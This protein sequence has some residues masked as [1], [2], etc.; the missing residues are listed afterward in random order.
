MRSYRLGVADKDAYKQ[1]ADFTSIS[2]W[3][4]D[5]VSACINAKVFEGLYDGQN[6]KPDGLVT[7]AEVCKL[8]YNISSPAHTVTI[9]VLTGGTITA[10]PAAAHAGTVIALTVTPDAGK[11]LKAGTLKY[12][13]TVIS[14]TT[15]T[16]PEKDVTI[17]AEFE[18]IPVTLD[19]I[20]ITS[21]PTKK[22]YTVGETLDL[23]GLVITANYSNNTHTAITG[24]T[25]TPADSST[26]STAGA[27]AVTASYTEGAVTKTATF[28]IQVNA[29]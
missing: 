24:Y 26:L 1:Y 28:T 6:F 9:G 23:S 25:T 18:D 4:Q 22:T 8:I 2:G 12:D 27:I 13:E 14:G 19:S 15:F 7:R 3:A 11:Q 16:M 21:E 5:S 20:T 29:A 17:T 10:N